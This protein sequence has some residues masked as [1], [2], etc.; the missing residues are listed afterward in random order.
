MEPFPNDE[1]I[2]ELLPEC[3]WKYALAVNWIFF[4]FIIIKSF[5]VLIQ[6]KFPSTDVHSKSWLPEIFSINISILF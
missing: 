2:L 1:N 4:I 6:L 3:Y 5:G